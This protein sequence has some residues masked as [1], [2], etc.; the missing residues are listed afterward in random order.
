[1]RTAYSF[2][3]LSLLLCPALAAADANVTVALTPAGEALALAT[4]SS[5][6]QLAADIKAKVDRAYQTRDVPGFLRAFTD[7]TA[8]SQRGLAVDYVSVPS[9]FIIGLGGNVAVAS[10]D[11]LDADAPTAGAAANLGFMLGGNLAGSG[12]PRWTLFVNGFYNS[13][14]TDRLSGNLASAGA[15]AQVKILQAAQDKGLVRAFRWTGLDLTSGIEYTRW[16]LNANKGLVNDFTVG[17]GPTA[18]DLRLTSEGKFELTSNAVTVPVELS[19]GFRVLGLLSIYGGV[20]IDFTAGSSTVDAAL[21]GQ[22]RTTDGSN[23]DVGTVTITADGDNTASPAAMHALAGL[24]L[25]LWK[26][27]AFVQGNVAQTPAASV[28]FGLRLVL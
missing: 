11:V 12:L 25:N 8:F 19:T 6:M 5:P 1:M 24:Q 14:S 26:L 23:T 3:C 9:S 17:S 15:H 4:G 13:A 18:T 7:A 28:S 10:K 16:K 20:G 27:K 2:A 21:S 22:A